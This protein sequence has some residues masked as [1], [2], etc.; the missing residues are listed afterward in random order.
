[1]SGVHRRDQRERSL[2][3]LYEAEA[4]GVG[5]ASVVDD[6][7]VAP[8]DWVVDLVVSVE[9]AT[10]E[11]D[12]VIGRHAVGWAVDRMPV[13]DRTLLRIATYELLHRPDV[14]TGA[15]INEA[16]ELAKTFSTDESGRFVNG[17]LAAVAAEARPEA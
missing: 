17:V 15:A 13:V 5:V 8:D 2:G 16:V 6:L 3:L 1:M 9:E 7:P 10:P 12:E 14:P 11:L 4:K